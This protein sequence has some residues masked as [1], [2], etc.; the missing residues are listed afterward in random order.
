MA[1]AAR[2]ATGLDFE[3][4]LDRLRMMRVAEEGLAVGDMLPDFAL[5]Y[6]G[7][8]SGPR[9]SCSTAGPLVLA[10]FRGGWCPYCDPHHGGARGGAAGDRGAGRPGRRHHARSARAHRRDRAQVAAI[11][12][13]LLSDPANGFARTCGLA[14]E[15]SPNHIRIHL[16]RGRDFPQ[17]ARRHDLAP[18]GA[19]GVRGR[20]RRAHRLRLRRRRSGALARSGGAAALR[21]T[22]CA[23]R[24]RYQFG[25]HSAFQKGM[26]RRAR[27]DHQN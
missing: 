18:A 15:L 26:A 22:P 9:T 5:G 4:E 2:R 10:L 8:R 19:G 11:A 16:E 17:P 14:Y 13:P 7:Q 1:A 27:C 6:G 12:Y 25:R 21:S 23:M 3:D 24:T 20:A